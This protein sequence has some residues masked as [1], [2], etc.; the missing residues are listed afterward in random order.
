[1]TK[2]IRVQRL[3]QFESNQIDILVKFDLVS[4]T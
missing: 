2:K 4:K 3:V 1:M